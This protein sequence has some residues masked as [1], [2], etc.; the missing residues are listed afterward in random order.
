[1]GNLNEAKKK[2]HWVNLSTNLG[3][4]DRGLIKREKWLF[5]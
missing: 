3:I 5:R 4:I 1:M 2:K